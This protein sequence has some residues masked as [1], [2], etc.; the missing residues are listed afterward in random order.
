MNLIVKQPTITKDLGIM[1][2]V[3]LRNDEENIF[4]KIAAILLITF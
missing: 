4:L 1:N 3:F 2:P